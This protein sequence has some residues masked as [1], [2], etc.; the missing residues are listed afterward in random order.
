MKIGIDIHG[1]STEHP[2]FFSTLTKLFVDAGHQVHILTGPSIN[3]DKNYGKRTLKEIKDLNLSYT[4]LFS[5]IDYNEALGAKIVYT[6]ENNPWISSDEW[7]KTKA[8]YCEKHKIDIM[9]DDTKEYGEFFKTPFVHF[10][11][12][13]NFK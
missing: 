5:I 4:H 11:T 13:K 1:V 8:V 3:P 9:L 2:E 7:N 12:I 6:N 10:S